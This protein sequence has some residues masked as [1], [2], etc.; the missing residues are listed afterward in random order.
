M[1]KHEEMHLGS[2]RV[3]RA[4]NGVPPL[5]TLRTIVSAGRRN[6]HARRVRYPDN[7]PFVILP[8]AGGGYTIASQKSGLLLT[9]A[10]TSDGALVTQQADTGS[11]LQHWTIS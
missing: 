8:L 10:S 3:S 1:T 11:G 7:C 6:Q 4:G 5:R 2:A 9:T